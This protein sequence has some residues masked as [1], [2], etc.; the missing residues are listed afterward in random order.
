MFPIIIIWLQGLGA[1]IGIIRVKKRSFAAHEETIVSLPEEI[2][3]ILSWNIGNQTLFVQI[4][5]E[6]YDAWNNWYASGVTKN[7]IR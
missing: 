6:Q 2:G 1:V 4:D 5:L 7:R 3:I